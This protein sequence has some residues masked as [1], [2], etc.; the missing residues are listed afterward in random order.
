MWIYGQKNGALVY[1]GRGSAL[2]DKTGALHVVSDAH[3]YAGKGACR[4]EPS[5]Q[6]IKSNGPIPRGL[7]AMTDVKDSLNTGP[8]TI[9]LRPDDRNVM[10][11]RAAFRIHGNDHEND[12]SEGCIIL[13]RDV[14]EKIWNSNDHVLLVVEFI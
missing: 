5:A 6:A 11:G 14:R 9:T 1:G 8:F 3:G 2:V 12:A 4:N 10:H 7:Y 13:A